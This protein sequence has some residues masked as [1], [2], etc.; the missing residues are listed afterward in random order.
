MSPFEVFL[1]RTLSGPFHS[2]GLRNFLRSAHTL[3]RRLRGSPVVVHYFH[4]EDDPY[5][6]LA[7]QSLVA[8]QDRYRI[9][10]ACHLVPAPVDA[11]AP[12]RPRLESWSRRDALRLQSQY[13][14][15]A[16]CGEVWKTLSL[17]ENFQEGAKL[18]DRMGHYLGA[19]FYFEGEW[20]WGVDRLHYLEERLCEAGLAKSHRPT[21][22]LFAPPELQFRALETSVGAQ[23][24]IDFFC[25]L[26]SPYTYLA[27]LQVRKLA[28]HY[29]ARL[30]LRPVLPMVMRGMAVPRAKKLYIARDVKREADRLGIRYG[31]CVDPLGEPAE[32]GLALLQ[33]AIQLGKGAEFAQS[34]LQGVFAEGIYAGNEAGLLL[35]AQRAGI[36]PTQM[37]EALADPSWRD[38]VEAN[39]QELLGLGLWGVPSFRVNDKPA[40][41]GNDRLW[42]VEQDLISAMTG[43]T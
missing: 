35:I 43:A 34:F 30:R 2:R 24:S 22:P 39:R 13:N 21:K 37:R 11:A 7:A 40:L 3:N 5:S 14:L 26:R 38:S 16:D 10:L 12:D 31:R 20:Y 36:G 27:T 23:A 9:A 42:M 8:L 15:H 32:R 18:R 28:Q 33:H 29:G 17:R 4:Q 19:T 1:N 41:W 6:A 25:S